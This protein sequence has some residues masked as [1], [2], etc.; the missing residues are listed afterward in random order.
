MGGCC[1]TRKSR[2]ETAIDQK[3]LKELVEDE[4]LIVEAENIR[5]TEFLDDETTL[6]N[7]VESSIETN[8]KKVVETK[9]AKDYENFLKLLNEIQEYLNKYNFSDISHLSIMLDKYFNNLENREQY[10]NDHVEI[11]KFLKSNRDK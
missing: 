2:F 6:Q 1:T 4:R 9:K 5:I 10:M 3:M 8:Q 11:I 7:S